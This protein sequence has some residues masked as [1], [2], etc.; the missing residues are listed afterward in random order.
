MLV[1][2][3]V[4]EYIVLRHEIEIEVEKGSEKH[5]KDFLREIKVN[6]VEDIEKYQESFDGIEVLDTFIEEVPDEDD[7]SYETWIIDGNL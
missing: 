1:T 4:K 3:G 6:G 7:V 2:I 5:V